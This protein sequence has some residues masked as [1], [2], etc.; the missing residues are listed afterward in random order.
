MDISQLIIEEP[1]LSVTLLVARISLA[2]V[3]L[4]SAIHKASNY[5]ASVTEFKEADVP[6][7]VFFL[8]LTI[9]LHLAASIAIVIGLFVPEAALALALFTVVATVK[10]HQFWLMSGDA[11][12]VSS[13][14][15]LANMAVFGGLLLVAVTGPG[16]YVIM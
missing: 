6:L 11:R 12:I 2:A 14:V 7:V 16:S 4:I 15:F 5:T 10:V 9:F 8:P 13:R 3:F 1:I